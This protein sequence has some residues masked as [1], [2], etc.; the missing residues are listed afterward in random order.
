VEAAVSPLVFLVDVDNTLLDSDRIQQD[1]QDHLGHAF[2]L[3]ARERIGGSWRICSRNSAI[4]TISERSSATA[5][6]IPAR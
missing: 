2:G 1:L 3:A 4:V 5:A 6:N